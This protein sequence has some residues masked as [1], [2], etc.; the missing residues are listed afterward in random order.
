MNKEIHE[1]I[2]K[3]AVIKSTKRTI[4]GFIYRIDDFGVL[5]I[6]KNK[7]KLVLI[8]YSHIVSMKTKCET[9]VSVNKTNDKVDNFLVFVG[10]FAKYTTTKGIFIGIL[11]SALLENHETITILERKN[12]KV[13]I[14]NSLNLICIK[15]FDFNLPKKRKYEIPNQEIV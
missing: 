3:F 9:S 15:E 5:M 11:V 14:L 12:E 4:K 13:V 8:N 7:T 2:G 10:R 6:S 1:L